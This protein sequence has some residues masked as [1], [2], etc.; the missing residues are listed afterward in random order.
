MCA[1]QLT[2]NRLAAQVRA[3]LV[4]ALELHRPLAEEKSLQ[5]ELVCEEELPEVLADHDRVIQVL[6][7]VIGNAIKF[8]PSGGRIVLGAEQAG[9]EVLF[10]IK[11]SGP[12]IPPDQVP[13]LFDAFWQ[14]RRGSRSGA[15][16]GLAIARG[17]VEAHGGRIWVE[18]DG[19]HG[20]TFRFSLPVAHTEAWTPDEL[21]H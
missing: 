16:L 5:L 1:G 15:G 20:S 6:A 21:H 13:Q 9:S 19:R 18:S 17:I 4:E 3:L 11:D 14:A 7:N 10:S 8:T 2:V 12:G